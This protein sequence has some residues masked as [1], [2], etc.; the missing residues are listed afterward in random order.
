M[1]QNNCKSFVNIE[2]RYKMAIEERSF[3]APIPGQALVAELGGRPW[4]TPP[5]LTTVDEAI[6]YYMERMSSEEFMDEL[7]E[8]LESGIPVAVIANTIQ[9]ANVMDGLHSI[10]VGMLVLPIIMEMM[11]FIGDSAGI[12]YN[13]GMEEDRKEITDGKI[14][15]AVSS[16]KR[17]IQKREKSSAAKKPEEENIKTEEVKIMSG[18]MSRRV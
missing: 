4:Q 10:D 14:S 1:L 8:I 16:F 3:D 12:K 2:K 6:D 9:L 13:T 5:K 11:M 15:K 7:V 17:D 18:L